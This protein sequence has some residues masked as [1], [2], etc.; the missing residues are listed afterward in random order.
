MEG[1]VS[2]IYGEAGV[3]KTNVVLWLLSNISA[4][5]KGEV[6]YISTEGPLYSAALS[7]Y[8]FK[9]NALFSEVY[10]SNSLLQL[11]LKVYGNVG[12]ELKA[13]AIDTVNNFY[14]SEVGYDANAGRVFNAMLAFLCDMSL[15]YGVTCLLTAQV[16]GFDDEVKMSGF[17]VLK[18][19]CDNVIRLDRLEGSMRGLFIELPDEVNLEVRYTITSKGIE[20]LSYGH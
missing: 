16:R 17:Q 11:I 15:K 19:W 13:V 5:S 18:Y 12:R 1:K 20:L 3:G 9:D 4:S 10:D 8:P 6:L 7:R 2:L 14:R